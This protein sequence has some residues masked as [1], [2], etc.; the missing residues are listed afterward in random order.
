MQISPQALSPGQRSTVRKLIIYLNSPNGSGKFW[1]ETT[2]PFKLRAGFR[3]EIHMDLQLL[4][5]SLVGMAGAGTIDRFNQHLKVFYSC[6]AMI[7]SV[8]RGM[9]D[10]V[11]A[12]SHLAS[13]LPPLQQEMIVTEVL[14]KYELPALDLIKIMDREVAGILK[15]FGLSRL[16]KDFL[17]P[18]P[19]PPPPTD[20]SVSPDATSIKRS[21][22]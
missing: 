8:T 18:S 20:G 7:R 13:A 9:K 14:L 11:A 6:E 22:D 16:S 12:A 17:S 5:D 21:S 10:A 15:L 19:L 4:R 1:S 2:L 3:A